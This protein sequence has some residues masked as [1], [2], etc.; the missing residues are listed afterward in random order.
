MAWS[1]PTSNDID[2]I[3]K[4]LLCNILQCSHIPSHA[5]ALATLPESDHGLGLLDPSRLAINCFVVPMA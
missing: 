2:A 5:Y 3:N 1:S 4:E